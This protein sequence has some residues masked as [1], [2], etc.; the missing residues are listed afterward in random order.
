MMKRTAKHGKVAVVVAGM[1][2]SG[3]SSL[4]RILSECGYALPKNLLPANSA[5]E[6]GYWESPNINRLND[7]VFQ[8]ANASWRSWSPLR[9]E[10]IAPAEFAALR[11]EAVDL[12][13]M[14][15]G[16]ARS[17]VVKDPRFCR[18]LPFWLQ[19]FERFSVRPVVVCP[20]RNPLE[21]A[22]SL[23]QRNAM[24]QAMGLLLWLRYQLDMEIASRGLARSFSSYGALLENLE[25]VLKK[26][27]SEAGLKGLD[28]G[29]RSDLEASELVRPKLRHHEVSDSVALHDFNLPEWVRNA[30]GIF[31]RW[32]LESESPSDFPA[33]DYMRGQFDAIPQSIQ[34]FCAAGE[35][36]FDELRRL[37]KKTDGL[38]QD[39]GK[40][41]KDLAQ[42]QALAN[43][44]AERIARLEADF[45]EA[46]QARYRHEALAEAARVSE[47]QVREVLALQ[48]GEVRREQGLRKA[49]ELELEKARVLEASLVAERTR[50]ED[51]YREVLGQSIEAI[52]EGRLAKEQLAERIRL[53]DQRELALRDRDAELSR[54]RSRID[55]LVLSRDQLEGRYR[56]V[57]GNSVQAVAEGRLAKE[58]LAERSRLW[59]LSEFAQK[60]LAVELERL[61]L[62][63]EELAALNGELDG[64]YREALAQLTHVSVNGRLAQEQSEE[65][66]RVSD[67]KHRQAMVELAEL[68]V[69][70]ESERRRF[71]DVSEVQRL[72]QEALK[73]RSEEQLG[74]IRGEHALEVG[75]LREQCASTRREAEV[76][77]SK[78]LETRRKR[79]ALLHER[80]INKRKHEALQTEFDRIAAGWGWWAQRKVSTA[81]GFWRGLLPS[82][83]NR[84]M[85]EEVMAV[86]RSS[87][88]D[89]DWYLGRY[90]DVRKADLDPAL[91][92]VRWGAKEGRD[93]GPEFSSRGYLECHSDVRASGM[94]PLL[95]F[96]RYGRQEK[97][98]LTAALPPPE[99]P[100]GPPGE[101]ALRKGPTT[102]AGNPGAGGLPVKAGDEAVKPFLLES[103]PPRSRPVW[104]SQIDL[105]QL[106]GSDRW[107]LGGLAI[108]RL[109]GA[110][111]SLP[112]HWLRTI[113]AFCVLAGTVPDDFGRY[114]GDGMWR[115]GQVEEDIALLDFTVEGLE[116]TFW[117]ADSRDLNLRLDGDFSG[118]DALRV[119]R[120]YQFAA[121]ESSRLVL[122]GEAPLQGPAPQFA[123][124]ALINPYAPIL[125]VISNG[126]GRAKDVSLIPFPSLCPGG[127]HEGEL[128]RATA[129]GGEMDVLRRHSRELALEFLGR[130]VDSEQEKRSRLLVDTTDALGSEILVSPDFQEWIAAAFKLRLEY[131]GPSRSADAGV[132][133]YWDE[134]LGCPP[135]VAP[136]REAAPVGGALVCPAAAYPTIRT[137]IACAV[138]DGLVAG[139]PV[140][141]LGGSAPWD[142][143]TIRYPE[144]MGAPEW[145]MFATRSRHP[146][147]TGFGSSATGAEPASASPIPE[148]IAEAGFAEGQPGEFIAPIAPDAPWPQ[149][150]SAGRRVRAVLTSTACEANVLP[151][152]LE[153]LALQRDVILDGVTVAAPAE[154][155]SPDARQILERYLGNSWAVISA[156]GAADQ[157]AWLDCA[158]TGLEKSGF[159]ENVLV[160]GRPVTLHDPRTLAV[161]SGVLE[162]GQVAT[163]SCVLIR[164]IVGAGKTGVCPVF[165]GF[166]PVWRRSADGGE[167]CTLEARM[168]VPADLYPV[169]SAGEA[170]VML[171]MGRWAQFREYRPDSDEGT[172]AY[173]LSGL[174]A[175]FA[176]KGLVNAMTSLVTVEWH[177]AGSPGTIAG[178]HS[179]AGYCPQGATTG[180]LCSV[181]IRLG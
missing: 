53:C 23:E 153:S 56:E 121:H 13:E 63:R 32:S 164:S 64:R 72:E 178:G 144:L 6:A 86:A 159:A 81:L 42:K 48:Q 40:T 88:F 110:P 47:Q 119:I 123:A 38:E 58:Q 179:L 9:L 80:D 79:D 61:R 8:A 39:L 33:L 83:A 170:L 69:S 71:A 44:Q 152:L 29:L 154:E 140:D 97:R 181:S 31:R 162:L 138:S 107:T 55:E 105:S 130:R 18:L 35:K 99:R 177:G 51:R 95:H 117:Y 46:I 94:N 5:N 2:R 11:N 104:A 26:I 150:L 134:L 21:I 169:V 50:L 132:A 76:L 108:A 37:R 82:Q 68:R 124:L 146:F 4:T 30:Y 16:S 112:A 17:V 125:L 131:W 3:T 114:Q 12:L 126:D 109:E 22:A 92:Y 74:L 175:E 151:A 59:E 116:P 129:I 122:V 174:G 60:E 161:L 78:Y 102:I 160:V 115:A 15:F 43:Q 172:R 176:A 85:Q 25:A 136:A 1:H 41:S 93:P 120:G 111:E 180:E 142:Q 166:M 20:V 36:A 113:S 147:V 91:H 70:L 89:A 173:S 67:A 163:A 155:V 66:L 149:H 19:V 75:R 106:K 167:L 45:P 14:E 77:K 165:S 118:S 28:K 62:Q 84:Q 100:K 127:I 96:E 171:E 24:P 57:L 157:D 133:A 145:R 65:A 7:K 90:P 73:V 98:R 139:T 143:V 158:F 128:G 27:A 87:L 52:A 103:D 148:V 141:S 10:V 34:G 54:A 137:L 168:E 156:T 101:G 49:L 135:G